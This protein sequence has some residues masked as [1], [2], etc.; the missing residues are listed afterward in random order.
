MT[1]SNFLYNLSMD[2]KENLN[3]ITLNKTENEKKKE[4]KNLWILVKEAE[5]REKE[6]LSELNQ[7]RATL[8]VNFGSNGK[9][10]PD[11]LSGLEYGTLQMLIKVLQYYDAKINLLL[12]TC[13]DVYRKHCLG[14]EDISWN[15]L[16]QKVM[17]TLCE[18]LGDNRFQSWLEELNEEQ[19]GND[20][21]I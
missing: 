6:Y 2:G 8:Q 5:E 4:P 7:L 18:V 21:E 17:T 16:D 10:V 3:S 12:E 9:V 11:V 15:E 14:Q 1:N 13:K 19:K 20:N